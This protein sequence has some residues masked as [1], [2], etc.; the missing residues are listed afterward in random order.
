MVHIEKIDNII[1]LTKNHIVHHFYFDAMF[2]FFG[3]V[4]LYKDIYIGLH[5]YSDHTVPLA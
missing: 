1:V 2:L 3:G 5:R 4:Y